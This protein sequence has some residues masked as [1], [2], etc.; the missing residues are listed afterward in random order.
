MTKFFF[1][2]HQHKAAKL[3]EA[4]QAAG[5]KQVSPSQARVVFFD[6]DYGI[7][8]K[9]IKQHHRT[10]K[11]IFMY[12][13]AGPVNLFNDTEGNAP[14][15]CIAA[16]FVT[17]VGHKEVLE[18]IDYPRP[19]ETIGWYLCPMKPFE[20]RAQA[21][22]ILFAPIHPNADGNLSD[23]DKTINA[24][25]FRR[26]LPLVENG[27][28]SLTV[29][30]LR[31]LEQNGL[32]TAESVNYIEG[33]PDQSYTEIDAADLV[34]S[35]QHQTIAYIAIARGVPVVMMGTDKPPRFGSPAKGNFEYAKSF[36]KYKDLLLYPFDI[37]SEM[38][39]L[40]LFRRAVHSDV[41]IADWRRR[42]VGEPFDAA[43]FTKKVEAY[44]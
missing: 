6:T 33:K 29:R 42:M 28:I 40:A 7:M 1:Y 39:T 34:I 22:K 17:A 23:V 38:D 8:R 18:R 44:L 35:H 32:W 41:E 37:L 9:T 16:N 27:I 10:G 31:Q 15:D 4:L 21:V 5:W 13:H 24:T 20:P 11:K 25:A 14:M 2:D 3:I 36:E 26:L 30:Y 19:I 43:R 12:P